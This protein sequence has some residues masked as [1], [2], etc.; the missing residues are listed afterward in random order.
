MHD[1]TNRAFFQKTAVSLKKVS[2]LVPPRSRASKALDPRPLPTD[3]STSENSNLTRASKALDPRPSA[4]VSDLPDPIL[5]DVSDLEDQDN[6]QD[7]LANN[8]QTPPSPIESSHD[9]DKMDIDPSPP[10]PPDIFGGSSQCL[11]SLSVFLIQSLT[12]RFS[13]SDSTS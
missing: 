4:P 3:T 9:A 11:S 10:L 7:T 13:N 2:V 5:P 12:L 6:I 8:A 1:S